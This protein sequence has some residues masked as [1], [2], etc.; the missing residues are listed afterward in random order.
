MD[1][2]PEEKAKELLKELGFQESTF[3]EFD[4]CYDKENFKYKQVDPFECNLLHLKNFCTSPKAV[5]FYYISRGMPCYIV[6]VWSYD[7]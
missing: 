6:R 3:Q 5:K 4:K 1:I 7:N 2:M